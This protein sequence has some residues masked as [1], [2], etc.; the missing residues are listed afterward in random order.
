MKG[1]TMRVLVV[2]DEE[3]MQALLRKALEQDEHH[4]DTAGSLAAAK[5]MV[6]AQ[7]YDLVITDLKMEE[8]QAGLELI[9][10]VRAS[11]ARAEIVLITGFAT[12][13]V[14]RKALERGAYHYLI[15][16]VKLTDVR[17]IAREIASKVNGVEP[18]RLAPAER[19]VF[20]NIVVGKNPRMQKVYELLPRIV[21]GTSTVLIRGESGTGKEVIARAI[22]EHSPRA[23]GPFIDVNCAALVD[24]LLEAELFGIEKRVATG[25]DAREG[26]LELAS[27]GTLFLDEVGDMSTSVQAK[28]LRVLQER[29]FVRVG[30]SRQIDVD[31]RI[32]AATNIDLEQAV[33]DRRFREDLFYRL[34]VITVEIPPLRERQ[35][36]IPLFVSHVLE[37]IGPIARRPIRGVTREALAL[38]KRYPWPGNIRELENTLEHA[39]VMARGETLGIED[40]PE[41]IVSWAPREDRRTDPAH[42][43]LP[44]DGIVLEDV[45]RD[46]ILQALERTGWKKTAAARLLG[47]T[48]R[49]LGYRIEKFG[50]SPSPGS[51][52]E[53]ALDGDRDDDEEDPETHRKEEENAGR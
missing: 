21:E 43:A 47:L 49:A 34:S 38:L 29:H 26:K 39:A 14:G 23:S 1:D 10:T 25:V 52:A 32:I 13:E 33:H 48:R 5:R 19:L 22:H 35:E 46:F 24:T 51:E 27:G 37:R 18:P 20:D 53:A 44:P 41:R 6:A 50:L 4:V 3:K 7:P 15:K 12:I 28:V 36:D 40:L 31:V 30:G 42:F 11:C 8:E 2:D 17:A 9:D 16:P 45:E